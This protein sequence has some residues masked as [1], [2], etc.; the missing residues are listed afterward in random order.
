MSMYLFSM[1]VECKNCGTVV[2][3]P[4]ADK[5]PT[6]GELLRERRTPSR[7]AGVQRR[8]GHLRLML[9]FLRFL[10]VATGLLG[11]LV[12]LFSDESISWT[13]R[14]FSVVVAVLV[15]TSLFVV[16]ALL[17]V[18]LD[19]EE[20]TRSTFRVQHLILEALQRQRTGEPPKVVETTQ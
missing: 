12:F 10:G 5:C 4:R 1:P 9:G 11:L 6:C 13:M 16:A 20:N 7:L 3:D 8:Y 19:V 17:D 15:G 2:D 14:I 18:A